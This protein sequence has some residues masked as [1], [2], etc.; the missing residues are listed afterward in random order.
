M[1]GPSEGA[2]TIIAQLGN[3]IAAGTLAQV[4]RGAG[5]SVNFHFPFSLLAAQNPTQPF[6]KEKQVNVYVLFSVPWWHTFQNE[7][8]G[9]ERGTS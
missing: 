9:R 2:K 4:G 7:V 8:G 6:G 3:D 5:L 1:G